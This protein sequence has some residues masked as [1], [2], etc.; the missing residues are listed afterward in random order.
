MG[1]YISIATSRES[2]FNL[3]VCAVPTADTVVTGKV[4]CYSFIV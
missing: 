3:E 2:V 4:N 1:R